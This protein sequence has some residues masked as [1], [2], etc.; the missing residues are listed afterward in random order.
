MKKYIL[1]IIILM[2]TSSLFAQSSDLIFRSNT[3]AEIR[4]SVS[5]TSL[6]WIYSHTD[7]NSLHMSSMTFQNENLDVS[8]DSVGFRLRG[9]TSRDGQKKPFKLDLNEFV[10]G[11]NICGIEKLN[12]RAEANDPSM[13]RSKLSAELMAKIGLPTSRVNYT[14]VYINDNYMGLYEIIEHVD[15]NFLS[16]HYNNNNGNLW[17][18]I[19]PADLNYRG[20]DPSNYYP[21]SGGTRPY[22]LKTNE[23]E[24][25]FT[26]LAHLIDVINNTSSTE[27]KDSLEANLCVSDFIKYL[28]V[29]IMTGSWD[30][31]RYLRNNYYLYYD[32]TINKFRFIPYDYD[33]TFG[34][35]WVEGSSWGDPNWTRINMYSYICMD[36]DGRPLAELIFDTP[37]YRD[38]FTHFIQFYTNQVFR[39]E[40]WTPYGDS[41]KAVIRPHV[42]QDTYY[43]LA[44]GYDIND[45]DDSY[46]TNYR[47]GHVERGL[48][49]FMR[50]RRESTND[51]I[52]WQYAPPAIYRKDITQIGAK[53]D[54]SLSVFASAGIK[55][56]ELTLYDA[57]KNEISS[58]SIPQDQVLQTKLI[59]LYDQWS[60]SKDLNELDVYYKI[61]AVDTRNQESVWPRH[62]FAKLNDVVIPQEQLYI[63]ELMSSN[64]NTIAD[65][66]GEFD[67]WVEIYNPGNSSV[68]LSGMFMS[69]KADKLNKWNFPT[70]THIAAQD[71]LIVW[72]DEDGDKDQEGLHANFKLSAKGEYLVLVDS[73]SITII[74]G[75]YFPALASDISFGRQEDGHSN[76]IY[77]NQ[78]T[79]DAYNSGTN[80]AELI[81][82]SSSLFPNYPNPFNPRTTISYQ[83]STSSKVELSVYDAT[84]K[85]VSTLLND[86][87]SA[88]MYKINWNASQLTSGLYLAV[89]KVDGSIFDTQKMLLIK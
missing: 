53:L 57:S 56:L 45:F 21:Y 10:P 23:I 47:K 78:A 14:K 74:D 85:K 35:D 60:L 25:D 41:I 48:Y 9:N 50:K 27:I 65:P 66:V 11:R 18:C 44:H 38:L 52:N 75:L 88:G 46:N 30:D 59:E 8:M 6:D 39:E 51:Q 84:G 3:V 89:L 43:P 17:K 32:P 7:S 24:Y 22:E 33:N 16:Y 20:S 37:E 36:N 2:I 12:L 79:P 19:Y 28:A 42:E 49:E 70:G 4:I 1:S 68:D 15:E 67:D 86:T 58:T 71:Y 64:D 5:Q 80:I 26:K 29:N 81:P 73:D 77:F 54:I 62:G 82:L 13:I 76:W 69:D 61:L 34:I 55:S 31:Y 63:N 83:L 87:Q 40:Q 72:C